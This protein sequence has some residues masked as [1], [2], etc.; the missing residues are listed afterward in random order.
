MKILD[1]YNVIKTCVGNWG[2][3]GVK[4]GRAKFVLSKNKLEQGHS[5]DQKLDEIFKYEKMK[6]TKIKIKKQKWKIP[7]TSALG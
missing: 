7:K 6:G 2:R 1:P 5:K 4:R 3:R